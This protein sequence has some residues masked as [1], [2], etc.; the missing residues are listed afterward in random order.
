MYKKNNQ[1]EIL[2]NMDSTSSADFIQPLLFTF[3]DFKGCLFFQPTYKEREFM[4][5][6]QNI[7]PFVPSSLFEE[8]K[9]HTGRPGYALIDLLGVS[10]VKALFNFR[11]MC[12][13]LDFIE[14]NINIKTILGLARV[15]SNAT[16]SKRMRELDEALGI[17]TVL[18]HVNK[19][20]HKD[21]ITFNLSIDSTIIE[22]RE[23][24]T[25]DERKKENKKRG[26]KRKGSEEE[27]LH[28]EMQAKNLEEQTLEENGDVG[29]Y[30]QTLNDKCSVTGKKNS[31]GYMDWRIGYKAHIAADDYGI[32]VAFAVTGANVHDSRVA[33]PLLRLADENCTY[34]YA[35]M[36]GGYSSKRIEDFACSLGK[37]PVIDF[38]ANRNGIKWE[39]DPAKRFR[40]KAR[41]TVERTNSELKANFLPDTLYARG[42][43]AIFE[44][45][46]AIFLAA[47]SKI[48]RVLRRRKKE[49]QAA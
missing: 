26:R 47:F 7:L 27:A 3:D 8:K 48:G 43:N 21:K 40:Y 1:K 20:F 19:C 34:L 31:K 10:M 49:S 9:A 35:L 46:L 30:L 13:T 42:A 23:A 39:M 17:E 41:T 24:P 18:A 22:A 2:P 32:P 11:C 4:D 12:D 6:W 16:V 14:S 15:P 45:K 25:K 33:I 36:D 37:V 44:I 5:L 38:K 28:K 29:T